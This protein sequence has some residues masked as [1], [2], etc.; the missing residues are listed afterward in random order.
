MCVRHASF[1]EVYLLRDQHSGV[2]IFVCVF[3]VHSIPGNA[4]ALHQLHHRHI[5]VSLVRMRILLQF[6]TNKIA[7]SL[8]WNTSFP[9]ITVCEIYNS[10]KI[11]ELSETYNG[12]DRDTSVDDLLADVAFFNGNCNSCRLCNLEA[13][14]ANVDDG[15]G[16]GKRRKRSENLVRPEMD[17]ADDY[18]DAEEEYDEGDH[19]VAS[20]ATGIIGGDA[21]AVT[22]DCPTNF[23]DI[24]DKYRTKCS[25]MLFNC[26]WNGRP[27]ECCD[28]F[29]PL[30]TEFGVCFAINSM[31][32]T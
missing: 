31:H 7:C 28:A 4:D 13:T 26:T 11:W 5:V 9:A 23:T 10:E 27:L 22:V 6:L 16:G 21:G 32:T 29:L 17:Y 1:A 19:A 25:A 12:A 3:L 18:V 8:E 2:G 30:A 20:D 24:L 15:E 14:S